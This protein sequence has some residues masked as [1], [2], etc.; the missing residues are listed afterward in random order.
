ML[1]LKALLKQLSTQSPLEHAVGASAHRGH[2]DVW[3][4]Q[5]AEVCR[6]REGC[7]GSHAKPPSLEACI[8][9][10]P[11]DGELIAR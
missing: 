5:V 9:K 3:P 10:A 6:A 4:R 8:K 7:F 2:S 11:N 1:S